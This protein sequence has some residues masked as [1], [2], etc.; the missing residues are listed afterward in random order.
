MS[1]RKASFVSPLLDA[2]AEGYRLVNERTGTSVAHRILT[3][4][5]SSSRRTGLLQHDSL[6]EGTAL[7]IAPTNAIHTFFMRFA[8]D[9]AFVSRDG[10]VV[11][12]HAALAPWRMA[13]ALR[14]YAVVELPAGT[15]SRTDTKPGDRLATLPG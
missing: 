9:V 4:F 3:A 10:R 12:T 1:A 15:L 14:A 13:A 5:D 11:K 8:I 2:G 6:P 7:V